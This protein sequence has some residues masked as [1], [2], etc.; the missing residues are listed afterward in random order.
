MS[1]DLPRPWLAELHDSF[2]LIVDPHG[3]AEVLAEMA[4]AAH[5]RRVV[6]DGELS[7]MPEFAE[8]ARLWVLQ[9]QEEAWNLGIFCR[10]P[11]HARGEG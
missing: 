5:R 1:L 8:A 9:E 4:F 2:E 7:H 3:R 11:E 6:D 10:G